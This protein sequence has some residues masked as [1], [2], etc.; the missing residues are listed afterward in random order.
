MAS[1]ADRAWAV[2]LSSMACMAC[3]PGYLNLKQDVSHSYYASTDEQ[4]LHE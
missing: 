4:A 1:T 2:V 3:D